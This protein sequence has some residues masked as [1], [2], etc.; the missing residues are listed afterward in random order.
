MNVLYTA[1]SQT[2]FILNLD[3]P[4]TLISHACAHVR[5]T[6]DTYWFTSL[7]GPSK[8]WVVSHAGTASAIMNTVILFLFSHPLVFHPFQCRLLKLSVT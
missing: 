4:P 6:G 3:P 7:R 1:R 2:L 8:Q 5:S